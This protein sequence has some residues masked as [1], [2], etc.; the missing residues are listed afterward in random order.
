MNYVRWREGNSPRAIGSSLA[1]GALG[2]MLAL[3]AAPARSDAT[4]N[5][6]FG[7]G[8]NSFTAQIGATGSLTVSGNA[9][10]SLSS[11]PILGT[12]V[13]LLNSNVSL[14]SQSVNVSLSP[15][16]I[17]VTTTPTGSV[18]LK[19]SDSFNA[20]TVDALPTNLAGQGPGPNGKADAGPNNG[21][22]ADAWMRGGVDALSLNLVSSQA[23]GFSPAQLN[24][25][26]GF[27]ILGIPVSI[28]LEVDIN[29][30]A[31]LQNL[32]FNQL[33]PAFMGVG[34]KFPTFG[35]GNHP[36]GVNTLDL[37]SRYPFILSAGTFAAG[38]QANL[39][40][41]LTATLLGIDIGLGNFNFAQDLGSFSQDFALFGD[42]RFAELATANPGLAKFFD[43]LRFTL[44][45]DL[46][47]LVGPINLPLTLSGVL[48]IT[49]EFDAPLSLGFL[50]TITFRGTFNGTLNY[51]VDATATISNLAY[52]LSTNTVVN[53]VDIPEA[54]SLTLLA[55]AGLG[56]LGLTVARRRPSA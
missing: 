30:S 43:D 8:G 45:A 38:A 46:S 41:G 36:N 55:I 1:L 53:A 16:P 33:T 40:V 39:G 14:P 15:N 52:Q 11:P 37:S 23:V 48:P 12:P 50:G 42:A 31:L 10:V 3:I 19:L 20:Q 26:A 32:T 24:G 35:D 44:G 21:T 22:A 6:T 27:S 29:A 9:T 5:T 2:G 34:Q 28:P 51:T 7:G 13:G 17:T 4:F 47:G 56:G 18:T 54:G 49:Q 25:S